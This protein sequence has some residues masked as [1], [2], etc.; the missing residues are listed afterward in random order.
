MCALKYIF[1]DIN[2]KIDVFGV[3]SGISLSLSLSS[4]RGHP[5]LAVI[6][7]EKSYVDG[8]FGEHDDIWC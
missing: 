2:I 8:D 7:R 1:F 4:H 3:G 6:G 5:P